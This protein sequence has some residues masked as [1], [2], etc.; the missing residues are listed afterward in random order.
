MSRPSWETFS[1]I[2]SGSVSSHNTTATSGSTA[3]AVSSSLNSRSNPLTS[4]DAR[5][6]DPSYLSSIPLSSQYRCNSGDSTFT[7]MVPYVDPQGTLHDP[8][9]RPFPLIKNTK[10]S[11]QSPF[12]IR[13]PFWESEADDVGTE[14]GDSYGDD[15]GYDTDDSLPSTPT[16]TA[17][18]IYY[19][20]ETHPLEPPSRAGSPSP[21]SFG[22]DRKNGCSE[23]G[24][25][26]KRNQSRG[27]CRTQFMCT[28]FSTGVTSRNAD[29]TPSPNVSTTSLPSVAQYA[30]TVS[31]SPQAMDD[32]G[33]ASVTKVKRGWS[34]R[35]WRKGGE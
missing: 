7:H 10:K 32:V 20:F 12:A 1:L 2:R 24:K 23:I 14:F 18:F 30:D 5:L 9:Y 34:V 25:K 28:K 3:V 17:P 33:V 31:A 15:E 8:D 29:Y 13:K 19:F 16:S 6:L 4:E 26:N 27:D 35:L 11:T 21:H 22:E